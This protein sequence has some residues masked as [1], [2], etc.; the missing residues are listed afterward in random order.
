[1]TG[2]RPGGLDWRH[3]SSCNGG[4]CVEVARFREKI[5]VR[6]SGNPTGPILTFTASNWEDFITNIKAGEFGAGG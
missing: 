3:G 6:D 1:M 4:T 5:A 2:G